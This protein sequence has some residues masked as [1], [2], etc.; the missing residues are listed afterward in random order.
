[1]DFEDITGREWNRAEMQECGVGMSGPLDRGSG[2]APPNDGCNVS[3]GLRLPLGGSEPLNQPTGNKIGSTAGNIDSDQFQRAGN[4]YEENNWGREGRRKVLG[5]GCAEGEDCYMCGG[6]HGA[7]TGGCKDRVRAERKM[8]RSIGG[9]GEGV[10][11]RGQSGFGTY[12]GSSGGG[13]KGISEQHRER[14]NDL[15]FSL[16]NQFAEE[17]EDLFEQFP[18]FEMNVEAFNM[19]EYDRLLL[20]LKYMGELEAYQGRCLQL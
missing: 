18:Q 14:L 8:R 20:F 13:S 16:E 12:R 1:M 11:S 6:D 4:G 3:G 15:G 5:N 19:N 2:S 7:Y 9:H 10:G 17:P